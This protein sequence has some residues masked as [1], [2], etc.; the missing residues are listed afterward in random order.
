MP[1]T[2]RA[3]MRNLVVPLEIFFEA[4]TVKSLVGRPYPTGSFHLIVEKD[5]LRIVIK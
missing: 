5:V 1:A 4:M 2:L 3:L